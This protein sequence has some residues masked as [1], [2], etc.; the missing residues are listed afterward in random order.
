MV[1]IIFKIIFV[2]LLVSFLASLMT[3]LRSFLRLMASLNQRRR[4]QREAS[5]H[6]R[7]QNPSKPPIEAEFKVIHRD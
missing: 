3:L 6:H 7:D 4:Y 5:Y 2:L 1:V